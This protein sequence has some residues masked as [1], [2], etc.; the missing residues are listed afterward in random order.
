MTNAR[1]ALRSGFLH[2]PYLK[3]VAVYNVVILLVFFLAYLAMDF[4]KHF[5]TT[6]PLSVVGK[7][8]FTLATHTSLGAPDV[9]PTTDF[10][11]SLV[12]LH[13]LFSWLQVFLVFAV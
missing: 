3:N 1:V 9:T 12:G 6:S 7:M 10:A 13:V 5:Q 11:R 2:I 4:N 8:Y